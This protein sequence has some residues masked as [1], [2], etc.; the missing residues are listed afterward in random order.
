[1]YE[2]LNNDNFSLFMYLMLLIKIRGLY[3]QFTVQAFDHFK[4]KCVLQEFGAVSRR[5]FVLKYEFLH[6]FNIWIIWSLCAILSLERPPAPENCSTGQTLNFSCLHTKQ[7]WGGD[8]I[9]GHKLLA[10][11]HC[12]RSE[13]QKTTYGAL[14]LTLWFHL[15]K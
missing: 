13:N 1:M 12:L 15:I 5:T 6:L 2:P 9:S 3:L 14:K 11:Y 10:S 4:I 8:I 7:Y